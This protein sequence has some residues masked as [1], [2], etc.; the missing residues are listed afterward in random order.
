MTT[1]S[2]ESFSYSSKV[3]PFRKDQK[4]PTRTGHSTSAFIKK[5]RN[6]SIDRFNGT[7][8][9]NTQRTSTNF[10]SPKTHSLYETQKRQLSDDGPLAA[11]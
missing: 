3:N 4:Q 5:V 9:Q 8:R 10:L 6:T 1:R 7:E 11:N 2:R